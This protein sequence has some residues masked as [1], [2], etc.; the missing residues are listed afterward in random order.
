MPTKEGYYFV[1]WF[2]ES[3]SRLE[4]VEMV[5]NRNYNLIAKWE[6][7]FN[8]TF[9][10]GL[11]YNIDKNTQSIQVKENEKVNIPD[12]VEIKY[13]KLT[14]WYTEKQLINEYDFNNE[15]TEDIELIR[16]YVFCDCRSIENVFISVRIKR[17]LPI[18]H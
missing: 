5:T 9:H 3:S 10:Y 1:G 16:E 4:K 2:E 12:E 6:R 14:G 13:Y 18:Y 15:I 7:L 17:E 8:I 11:D